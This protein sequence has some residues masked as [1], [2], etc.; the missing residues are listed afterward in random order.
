M[1]T[2]AHSF[3][4]WALAKHGIGAGRAAGIAGAV[5]AALPDAPAFAAVLCFWGDFGSIPRE[6]LLNSIYF[7]GPFGAAGTALHSIVVVGTFWGFI[8]LSG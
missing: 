6:E 8:G 7:T 4:T 1:E 5:G 2:Y 3:F